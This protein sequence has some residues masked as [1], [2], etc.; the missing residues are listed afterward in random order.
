MSEFMH[1]NDDLNRIKEKRQMVEQL[2]R[3]I[4][5]QAEA[6]E[7][8]ERSTRRRGD[9]NDSKLEVLQTPQQ[10]PEE[11]GDAHKVLEGSSFVDFHSISIFNHISQSRKRESDR[12][13]SKVRSLQSSPKKRAK[14]QD[15]CTTFDNQDE[16]AATYRA[17]SRDKKRSPKK[18]RDK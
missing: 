8:I 18:K 10:K 6:I 17:K 11:V 5:V 13:K 16:Q 4:Q 3:A 7:T 14:E 15:I 2:T 1:V 9:G 12:S